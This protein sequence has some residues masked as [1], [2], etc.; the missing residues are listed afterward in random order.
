MHFDVSFNLL[1]LIWPFEIQ[2]TKREDNIVGR[3]IME[4]NGSKILAIK[5]LRGYSEDYLGLREAKDIIDAAW[6]I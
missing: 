1:G 4:S 5:L 3:A 6:P 2:I